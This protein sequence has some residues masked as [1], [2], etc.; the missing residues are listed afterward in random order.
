MEALRILIYIFCQIINEEERERKRE[1][2][3]EKDN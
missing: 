1:R 2:E 3:K